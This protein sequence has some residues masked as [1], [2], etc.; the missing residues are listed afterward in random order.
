[1]IISDLLEVRGHPAE[2]G[3]VPKATNLRQPSH[4]LQPS[5]GGYGGC[6]RWNDSERRN[7]VYL[8][9]GYTLQLSVLP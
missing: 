7:D 4:D 9:C 6:Q 2:D 3:G 5:G 8:V 1:M